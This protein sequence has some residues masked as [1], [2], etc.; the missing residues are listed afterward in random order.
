MREIWE[1]PGA[2]TRTKLIRATVVIA[3][4]WACVALP[5]TL[6][7]TL[8]EEPAPPPPSQRVLTVAE[9]LGLTLASQGLQTGYVKLEHEVITPVARF[10]VEE[11]VQAASGDSVGTVSSNGETAQLL[12]AAGTVFLRGDSA[13]WSTLGVPTAFIGWVDI[14]GQLGRIPFPLTEAA[15]ALVPGP[16]SR[17][18]TANPDGPIAV[19]RNEDVTADVTGVGITSVTVAD[20][21]ATVGTKVPDATAQ[22]NTATAEAAD[23]GRL[24]GTS[25]GLTVIEPAAPPPSPPPAP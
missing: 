21:S 11:T 17:I 15:A 20:R 25:G 10:Q 7:L 22:L 9:Q 14:G 1:L 24:D 8:R 16:Q 13:F 4:V 12:V 5:L 23:P 6:W 19:Y 2:T 3:L 18:D